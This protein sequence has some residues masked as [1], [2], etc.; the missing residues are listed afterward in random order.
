MRKSQGQGQGKEGK[1][2]EAMKEAI[3]IFEQWLSSTYPEAKEKMKTEGRDFK[4]LLKKDVVKRYL[5]RIRAL[6]SSDSDDSTE[7][8]GESEEKERRK[9]GVEFAGIYVELP[10]GKRLANVLVN[11]EQPGGDDWDGLRCKELTRLRDERVEKSLEGE[12]GLWTEKGG[13]SEWH[14][15]CIAWAWS[16]VGERRLPP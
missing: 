7:G 9:R 1:G 16:P 13:A 8:E 4:P 11:D 3:E 5:D 10:K 15:R 6:E 2:N 14:L 12:D